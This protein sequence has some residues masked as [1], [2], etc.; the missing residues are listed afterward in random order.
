MFLCLN[1]KV[2]LSSCGLKEMNIIFVSFWSNL[3]TEKAVLCVL[4]FTAALV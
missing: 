3:M 2:C 4:W 1:V